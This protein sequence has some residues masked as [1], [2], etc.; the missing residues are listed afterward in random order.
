MID[1]SWIPFEISLSFDK[2]ISFILM[3]LA[4]VVAWLFPE[5]DDISKPT[6]LMFLGS[7]E[8]EETSSVPTIISPN[9]KK[10]FKE[11]L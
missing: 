11:I 9:L 6:S 3:L 1:V 10:K 8:I 2:N 7:E 5:H 4:I